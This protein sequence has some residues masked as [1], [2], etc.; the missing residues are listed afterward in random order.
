[1]AEIV[2]LYETSRQS[3]GSFTKNCVNGRWNYMTGGTLC[4]Q[5]IKKRRLRIALIQSAS[6]F[7]GT[8]PLITPNTHVCRCFYSAMCELS[9][10]Q[11]P[12]GIL[13]QVT[14]IMLKYVWSPQKQKNSIVAVKCTRAGGTA[15]SCAEGWWWGVVWGLQSITASSEESPNSSPLAMLSWVRKESRLKQLSP[16]PILATNSEQCKPPF[17]S[18]SSQQGAKKKNHWISKQNQHL[19]RGRQR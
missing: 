17:V 2:L 16:G 7:P 10:F 15:N 3:L 14:W 5:G 6:I 9:S 12:H 13:K 18:V 19:E 1:M 8:N 4:Y 11:I